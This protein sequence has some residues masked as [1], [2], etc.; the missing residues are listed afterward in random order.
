[1]L[2]LTPIQQE[3]LLTIHKFRSE[4]GY[5]PT[6]RELADARG[7]QIYPCQYQVERLIDAGYLNAPDN[8]PRGFEFTRTIEY[9]G[10]K[11][12]VLGVCN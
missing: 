5:M 8:R 4:N 10:L 1:M 7:T 11:I 12:P 9:Q 6:F 3:T 2:K